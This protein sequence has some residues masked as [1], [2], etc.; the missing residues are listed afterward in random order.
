M[1]CNSQTYYSQIDYY[2]MQMEEL[3]QPLGPK[4]M[5]ATMITWY[6][7]SITNAILLLIMQK[8]HKK[9]VNILLF[10]ENQNQ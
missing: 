9:I 5:L 7:E 2:A 4:S 1:N 8:Y 6:S 10:S 3:F